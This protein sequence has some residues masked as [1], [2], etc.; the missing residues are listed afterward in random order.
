MRVI[1]DNSTELDHSS[2]EDYPS[3]SRVIE[4]FAA[5]MEVLMSYIA[6]VY[7]VFIASPSDVNEERAAIRQVLEKWNAAHTE[8][9]QIVL[10]PVAWDT[11]VPP[12]TG[13][14]PQSIINRVASECDLLVAVFRTRIG[15][16]TPEGASGTVEEIENHIASEKPAMIYFH[17]AEESSQ[18]ADSDQCA[19][20]EDFKRSLQPRGLY[21]PYNGVEDFEK[22][23]TQHLQQKMNREPFCSGLELVC[24]PEEESL[25]EE[26]SHKAKTLLLEAAKCESGLFYRRRTNRGDLFGTY[27]AG[28]LSGDLDPRNVAEWDSAVQDLLAGDLVEDKSGSGIEYYVTSGGFAAADRVMA[29]EII[30]EA[31]RCPDHKMLRME[32]E[33]TLFLIIGQNRYNENGS[34]RVAS[35]LERV[36]RMLEDKGLIEDRNGNRQF[37]YL[38][39]EGLEFASKADPHRDT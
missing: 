11:D 27:S 1:R 32:S 16:P 39:T 6:T 37:F 34:A 10:L 9:R 28:H 15:T 25:S 14:H 31:S 2:S 13:D 4:T 22:K 26:L 3:P 19:K 33:G 18:E 24:G 38:T 21:C 29:T 36:I 35:M 8:T 30:A 17:N 12:D 7:K 5:Q 23:F 20:L